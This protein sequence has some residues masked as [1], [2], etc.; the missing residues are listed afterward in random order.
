MIS[1]Y[2]DSIIRE[3]YIE[4]GNIAIT[5][6]NA[7]QGKGNARTST[8][9]A[10]YN[11]GIKIRLLLKGL[12]FEDRLSDETINRYLDCLVKLAQIRRFGAAPVIA[13]SNTNKLLLFTKGKDG[14]NIKGDPGD[15][16][17]VDVVEDTGEDQIVVTETIVGGIKTFKLKF[18]EYVQPSI[19]M[20]INT[21]AL[22]GDTYQT[23]KKIREQGETL[24]VPLKITLTKGSKDVIS[25]AIT[26]PSSLDTTYQTL[27]DLVTL[28]S[29]GSQV[30]NMNHAGI[31]SAQSYIGNIADEDNTPSSSDSLS[32]V[33][34]FLFGFST[35]ALTESNLYTQLT[36]M[37]QN[38]GDKTFPLNGTDGYPY[39]GYPSEYGALSIIKDGNGFNVTDLFERLGAGG[40][41]I[42]GGFINVVAPVGASFSGW[43]KEYIFY[44]H[45]LKTDVSNQQYQAI[46]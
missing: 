36:K 3:S 40:V 1:R 4:L 44:R 9:K 28:N 20:A 2:K 45:K 25:S 29:V 23:N 11:R 21:G 39:F 16:A 14:I 35:L 32:F 27:L 19:I 12:M 10:L 17:T 46:F 13:L 31:D 24:T 42:P 5:V 38:Q 22:S 18:V 15:D 7:V 33:Y 8:I 26:T 41:L 30:I 37:I 43:S 6:V 34:P